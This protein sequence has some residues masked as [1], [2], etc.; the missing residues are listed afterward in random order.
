MWDCA[1]TPNKLG[2]HNKVTLAWV[3]RDEDIKGNE[4]ADIPAKEQPK[5]RIMEKL[6][7]RETGQE[8]H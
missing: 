4:K 2:K 1:C 8:I 5:R 6:F 7:S 3:S